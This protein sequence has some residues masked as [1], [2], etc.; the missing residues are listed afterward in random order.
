MADCPQ[1]IGEARRRL[2]QAT[3]PA[4][5]A[6]SQRDGIGPPRHRGGWEH[7][8][9]SGAPPQSQTHPRSPIPETEQ[10]ESLATRRQA[11]Y[12][13][14]RDH[15]GGRFAQPHLQARRR[16]RLDRSRLGGVNGVDQP[17]AS[18]GP[19]DLRTG[20]PKDAGGGQAP[21]KTGPIRGLQWRC[22]PTGLHSPSR[23]L[24]TGSI[25][26]KPVTGPGY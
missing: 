9:G 13:G 1:F 22:R 8:R 11:R 7:R 26:D 21:Q 4:R 2:G 14:I 10:I 16:Q 20:T 12:S 3:L 19:H 17:Y 24:G 6:A 15:P 18:G 23:T 25:T 5:S